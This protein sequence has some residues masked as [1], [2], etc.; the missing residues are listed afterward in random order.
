MK[1]NKLLL[2]RIIVGTAAIHIF[3]III[4]LVD[5]AVASG[6]VDAAPSYFCLWASVKLLKRL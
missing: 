1:N 5:V 6:V 3:L 2:H 4:F